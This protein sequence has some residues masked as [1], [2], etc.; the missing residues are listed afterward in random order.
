MHFQYGDSAV[1]FVVQ[2]PL[3]HIKAVIRVFL[4][5]EKRNDI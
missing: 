3:C 5:R 4:L 2:T 1:F